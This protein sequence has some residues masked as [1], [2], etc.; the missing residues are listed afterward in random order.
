MEEIKEIPLEIKSEQIIKLPKGSK[1]LSVVSKDNEP[2]L[3]VRVNKESHEEEVFTLTSYGGGND[4]CLKPYNYTLYEG[5]K[6]LGTYDISKPLKPMVGHV[7]FVKAE[8][9][10]YKRNTTP[11]KKVTLNKKKA[12]HTKPTVEP[13]KFD[14]P[15]WLK[16]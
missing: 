14:R 16:K 1:L 8:N 5:G 13:Y 2:I 10:I 4:D 15:T 3:S 6:Y 12:E 7:F 11:R 9:V